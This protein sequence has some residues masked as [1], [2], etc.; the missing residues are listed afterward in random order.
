LARIRRRVAESGYTP[1]AGLERMR[2]LAEQCCREEGLDPCVAMAT[3]LVSNELW[4]ETLAGVPFQRRLLLLPQCL[5]DDQ[6]C[7]AKI[8][9]YGLLCSACGRC[10]LHSLQ[11]EAER[12][13]YVV[14]IAEG[15]AV[16]TRLIESGQIE[17]VVGVSCLS[18]LERVW[19]YMEA[20]AVPG[21]AIPLLADGC[22]QTRFD[23]DWLREA[24]YTTSAETKRQL[25]L[26]SLRC[27]VADWFKPA[28]LA[29][30]LG[31]PEGDTERVGQEWLARGGKRWRPFLAVSAARALGEDVEETSLQRLAIAVECFHKAS[32]IHDDIEDGDEVRYEGQTL[33][34]QYGTPFALNVGDFL[35]GEGYRLIGECEASPERKVQM[36][37]VAARGHRDLCLGQGAELWWTANGGALDLESVLRIFQRKTAPAFEV[38]LRM[39]AILARGS[40]DLGQS[41]SRYSRSLGVAYQIRDD[42][43][44]FCCAH[45]SNDVQAGRLSVLPAL[46][47][48]QAGVKPEQLAPL[49]EAGASDA[50]RRQG[51]SV[52]ESSRAV[53]CGL[54]LMENW[55]R[56]AVEALEGID[57][58]GLKSLLRRVVG[59]IFC[60]FETMGCCNDVPGGNAGRGEEGDRPSGS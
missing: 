31:A 30:V 35:L 39:G 47:V 11:A 28:A 24:M 57:S 53:A 45:E 22:R 38:A 5:R 17:A 56:R 26:E 14:M 37:A 51:L 49:Y 54:Q 10:I 60:D 9:E 59:R 52:L 12:L 43:D 16:V 1:P 20:A 3:V 34:A 40:D 4:R 18:V 7:P 27:S 42:L 55:K 33:H 19:P 41:L 2:S 8:D 58:V 15:S 48:E 29:E 6:H 23:V 36:F 44:D 25:D 21:I 32:L 13:G 46:A 50:A